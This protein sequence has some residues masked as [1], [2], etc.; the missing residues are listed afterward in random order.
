MKLLKKYWWVALIVVFII[1]IV[2][3]NQNKDSS[4]DEK[5][6]SGCK[7]IDWDAWRLKKQAIYNSNG[8]DWAKAHAQML[9]DGYCEHVG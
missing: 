3:N 7:E 9:A 8:G 4:T 2:L 1:I 5:S 6:A